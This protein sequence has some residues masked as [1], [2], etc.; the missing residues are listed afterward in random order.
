[1]AKYKKYSDTELAALV[2]A[3]KK[4]ASSDRTALASRRENNFARYMGEPYGDE[5]RG[6]S[7]IVTQQCLEA[8]EWSLPSLM[9]VFASSDQIAEF[10]PTGPQDEDAA[11]QESKYVNHVFSQENDGFVVLYTWVKDAL[12][13]PVSYVKVWWE[14]K[15]ET[16]TEEYKGLLA[17]Q[18]T[19]LM[20]DPDLS[21][22]E[23]AEYA[24]DV[25]LLGGGTQPVPVYDL[26]MKRTMKTGVIRIIPVP[27]EELFVDNKLSTVSLEGCDFICHT[28]Y[29]TRSDLVARGYNSRV[30]AELADSTSD[31]QNQ[32]ETANRAFIA[33]GDTNNAETTDKATQL[34]QVDE[35]YIRIDYDRDGIAE[36]RKITVSGKE[37][38]D[39][40]E[41]DYIPFVACSTVPVPHSHIGRAWQELVED[42]QRV[43]TTL[44]RQML[45]NLYRSNNPRPIIGPGV[46]MDDLLNDI[47]NAPIRAKNIDNVRMEPTQCVIQNVIPAF[48]VLN[49]MKETRTGVSRTTMGLDADTLSRVTKG[50]FLGSLEQANQ[51]LE[52]LARVIAEFSIK[53][54]FLKIHKL[55]LSYQDYAKDAKVY[56]QWVKVDPREWKERD[57]MTVVVG[58]G[59]GNK[60]AQAEAL[61]RVLELQTQILTGGKTHLVTDMNLFNAASRLVELAGMYNP[62]KYFVDPSKLPPQ[63]EAPKQDPAAQDALAAAQMEMAKVEREKASLQH[64]RDI[65][66]LQLKMQ[67]M[68]RKYEDKLAQLQSDNA[69]RERELQQA[70]REL[71]RKEYEVLLNSEAKQAAIEQKDT[72]AMNRQQGEAAI[73]M[74]I[75]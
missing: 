16:T 29:P 54:L 23:Q 55:L 4:A 53:P 17:E 1:M 6:Q 51:R 9:R 57:N 30:V 39:N 7:R 73:G 24:I 37:V 5:R 36:L 21:P 48:G 8:V 2:S 31:R 40:E 35:A 14:E 59:T 38:L 3:R 45:N 60:Q 28:T 67:E 61:S 70:D 65:A 12:M 19:Q 13:Q 43:Y 71:T 62:E 47:P 33:S 10:I 46:N 56:G 72:M 20:N 63:Q 49:D 15:E 27:Q 50:A 22:V 41:I 32:E 25:P 42:L 58:L 66:E 18:L 69:F 11:R 52:L 26:K 44:T 74:G 34:V 64:Q 68:A 75:T